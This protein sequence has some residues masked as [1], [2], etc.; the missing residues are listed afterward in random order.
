MKG[1]QPYAGANA[2][3]E[4]LEEIEPTQTQSRTRGCLRCTAPFRSIGPGHRLCDRCRRLNTAAEGA[5]KS[6]MR[7]KGI[8][9]S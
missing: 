7:G 5:G 1:L 2:V 8:G 9:G 3:G 4:R 6:G